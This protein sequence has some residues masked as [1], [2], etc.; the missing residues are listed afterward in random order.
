MGSFLA[1]LMALAVIAI[2]VR[3]RM[4]LASL[5][6]SKQLHDLGKL[7]FGFTVFWAYLMWSQYLVI[8]YGNLPEETYFIF[9]RLIGPWKPVGVAVFFL[10]LVIPFVGLL[11]VK[12]KQS[13][14]VLLPF[15]ATSLRGIW[16]ERYLQNGPAINGRRGPA[17]GVPEG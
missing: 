4:G 9:Y 7:S 17:L 11:A 3:R 16:L 10:V 1:A 8:W 5:I 13:P 15:A 2:A 12:P 14:P 6:S